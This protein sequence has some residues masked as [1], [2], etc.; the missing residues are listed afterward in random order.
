MQGRPVASMMLATGWYDTCTVHI[1]GF[2]KHIVWHMVHVSPAVA[3]S[4]C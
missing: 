2:S 1:K 4:G 3:S